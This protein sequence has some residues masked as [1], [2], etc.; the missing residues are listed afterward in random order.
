MRSEEVPEMTGPNPTDFDVAVIG[1]ACA[2]PGARTPAEFWENLCAGVESVRPLSDEELLARGVPP[3]TLRDPDYVKVASTLDDVESFDAEFFGINPNEARS[4]DPQHRLFLEVC[5]EALEDAGYDPAAYDGDI[6]VFA[7]AGMNTYLLEVLGRSAAFWQGTSPEQMMIG[8]DKDF[9]PSRA[10]YKLNL[11]GPSINVNTACSTSLVALHL[12]RHSLLLGDS[13]MALVG[14]VSITLPNGRGYRYLKDGFQSP[15][16]HCRAFDAE[17]RGTVWGDGAGV[18]VLK[19]LG[20][21]LADGDRILATVKGS[22]VNNDGARKVGYTAPG[23]EG[24]SRVIV[25]ALAEAGVSPDEIGYVEA[26]G[27]GT[28]LGDPIEVTALTQAFRTGTDR[29]GYCAIG[30]VK[31][32]IGHLNAAAGIAGFMKAVLAVQQ[33]QI[34]ASLNH[35]TPNP[36]IDFETSPFRV[37]TSL[38]PWAA[39]GRPRRAG[40]SSMGIGGTNCHVIIEQ[41]P[42]AV[43]ETA[44]EDETGA[45]IGAETGAEAAPPR[46]VLPLSA[47]TATALA[48]AAERLAGHLAAHPDLDIADVA[49]TLQC[50]R[51]HFPHRRAVV[52][53]DLAEAVRILRE[54]DPDAAAATRAAASAADTHGAAELTRWL[55]GEDPDWAVI[56]GKSGRARVALPTYPFERR[57]Y[58]YDADTDDGYFTKLPDMADWFSLPVWKPAP[59]PFGA[60]AAAEHTC[61]VLAD[62]TGLGA[63]AAQRMRARGQRVITVTA[64]TAYE[65]IDDA[66]FT[67]DPADGDGYSD[68]FQDLLATGELPADILFCWPLDAAAA[69]EDGFARDAFEADQD[70]SLFPIVWIAEALAEHAPDHPVRLTAVTADVWDVTGGEP[71]AVNAGTTAGACLVFQQSYGAVSA[72]CVD[73]GRSGGASLDAQADQVLSELDGSASEMLCAY[74]LGRRYARS[75]TPVRVEASAPRAAAL[76]KD[77]AY[78]VFGALEGIGH[79]IAEHI[80]RDVGGRLLILEEEDFPEPAQWAQWSADQGPDDPISVRI[81]TA[82]ELIAEGAVFV[83]TLGTDE[84]ANA[85]LLAEAEAVAGPLAGVVHAPGA[86]NAKR[87][88]TMRAVS[89]EAWWLNFDAVGHTLVL[90]DRVLGDRPLDFRIMTNSLGSVLGGDGFF[91]IAT[92]GGF[93][94]AYTAMRARRGGPTWSVQCW[95][96]WTVEWTGISRFLP[97]SLFSRVEPSVLTSEEGIRCF[98]RAFAVAGEVEVE[99]SATDLARRYRKWVESTAAAPGA[100]AGRPSGHPRPQLATPFVSPRSP[101]EHD[102]ADLFTQLL[103]VAT[104]GADDSFFDLGGHSLLGVELAAEVRRRFAIDM[105]LYLLYGMSTVA[106]LAAHIERVRT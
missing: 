57:R 89:V 26:H 44:P 90:L 77:R 88:S 86:S 74:R 102:V 70:R 105:D 69:P 63:A 42:A 22:A 43:R 30:S 7:G 35:E 51:R 64:G 20:T 56:W 1:M 67:L 93:A 17:A 48:A 80:V 99:I 101:L 33:G 55:A 27:T 13:D 79:Q 21:A 82:Q 5:W 98:E 104:V 81:R 9:L 40:I 103:G 61:L 10:S 94:K 46:R 78:L 16:G 85:R 15:D 53:A 54:S 87:I 75:Y 91:H 2:F 97:P 62:D 84:A 39:D 29:R 96:S 19:R 6:G 100:P 73:L 3:E 47:R 34:P 60:V 95:D 12:A 25:E 52:A 38:A 8:N 72:R 37:Q 23:V 58:W 106:D 59:L 45:E 11:T 14:G 32:N 71:F 49:Y 92:V 18:V 41:A 50:G 83:G 4:I 65:R 31:T 68:L 24:Q 28:P 36:R 76:E 66:T